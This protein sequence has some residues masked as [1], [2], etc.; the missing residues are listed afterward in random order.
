ME[1]FRIKTITGAT[2]TLGSLFIIGILV[3]SGFIDWAKVELKPSLLV[4]KGRK[5]RM[6]VI[7]YILTFR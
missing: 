5:E 6:K 7:M 2:L 1:D 3:V 4:D